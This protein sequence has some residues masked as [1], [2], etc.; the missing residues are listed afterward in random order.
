MFSRSNPCFTAAFHISISESSAW[1]YISHGVF[2]LG[3]FHFC[4]KLG[5]E[6][7]RLPL[8]PKMRT[9]PLASKAEKDHMGGEITGKGQ[10]Q[11]LTLVLGS[12]GH[13]H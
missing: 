7:V 3:S 6:E 8:G 12:L 5:E 2:Y 1:T 11:G 13:K 10:V 9:Q 4:F